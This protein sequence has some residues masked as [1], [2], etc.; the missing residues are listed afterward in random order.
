MRGSGYEFLAN[1]YQVFMRDG[2]TNNAR[3]AD[4]GFRLAMVK[5]IKIVIKNK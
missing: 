4:I 1:E 5:S 3:M 2:A